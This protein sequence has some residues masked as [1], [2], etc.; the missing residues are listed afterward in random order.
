MEIEVCPIYQDQELPD[1]TKKEKA[2]KK[3]TNSKKEVSFD[4]TVKNS[5]QK[6][7]A[8]K[9]VAVPQRRSIIAGWSGEI[10]KIEDKEESLQ[11]MEVKKEE[12]K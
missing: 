5:T 1:T 12:C 6:V 7:F 4:S 3:S 10:E 8:D 11:T 2:L 9:P